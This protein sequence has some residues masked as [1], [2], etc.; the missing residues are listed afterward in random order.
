MR[1]R[2]FLIGLALCV[3]LGLALPYNRMVIQGSYMAFYFTDRG[4]LFL[5]F[6]WW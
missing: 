4:S 5:F 2:A 6:A 3:F 1:C